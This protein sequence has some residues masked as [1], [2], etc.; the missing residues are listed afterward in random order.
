MAHAVS[1]K[2][3]CAEDTSVSIFN[4]IQASLRSS[5]RV[6]FHLIKISFSHTAERIRLVSMLLWMPMAGQ[7]VPIT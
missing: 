1:G 7:V 4:R 5:K 6:L 2:F 3:H